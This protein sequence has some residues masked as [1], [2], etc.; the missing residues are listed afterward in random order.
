MNFVSEERGPLMGQVYVWPWLVVS[1]ACMGRAWSLWFKCRSAKIRA[2]P[3]TRLSQAPS[4]KCSFLPLTHTAEGS[5]R[6]DQLL[7]SLHAH[8]QAEKM[9]FSFLSLSLERAKT[10]PEKGTQREGGVNN[11]SM[12]RSS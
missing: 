3:W 2:L 5:G 1:A 11:P 10:N 9:F 12:R 7:S 6:E 8:G 4:H